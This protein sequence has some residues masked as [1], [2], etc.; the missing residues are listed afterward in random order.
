M[1]KENTFDCDAYL[2]R[3]GLSDP[4]PITE[5]GLEATHRAHVYTIPFENFDI[6]LGRGIDLSPDGLFKKIILQPRGGYCF[7]L[8]GL[9]LHLLQALGFHA[10]PL[11]AR[12]HRRGE[13]GGR[14]HQL[15]LVNIQGRDWIADVGFG[16]NGLRAPIPMEPEH[17]V[18]HDDLEF[19]LIARSPFGTMLQV[20]E[21]GG[22]RDLY[23]FDLEHVCAGDIDSGNHYT[24]TSPQSFFTW[25]RVASLPNPN[26]RIS[27]QDF[28]LTVVAGGRV[29]TT[30]L[31]P[32]AGYLDKVREYFG[33]IINTDYQALR[34][35]R[36]AGMMN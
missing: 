13:P 9:Y 1:G 12:V 33:I 35:A 34:P 10:R 19:R 21:D 7:E 28:N 31:E 11:L 6:L 16:A 4:V 32:G 3:I 2:A 18:R 36:P 24:S 23:S 20:M 22:W 8:N 14:H 25:I 5:D 29:T 30:E 17:I 15:S 27:L 26:G